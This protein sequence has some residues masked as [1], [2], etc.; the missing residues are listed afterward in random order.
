MDVSFKSQYDLG[1]VH[2]RPATRFSPRLGF[3]VAAKRK[4]V[5]ERIRA[6][7]TDRVPVRGQ[8]T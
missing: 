3:R 1:E 6:K 2:P 8:G 7:Y 4:E 5:S